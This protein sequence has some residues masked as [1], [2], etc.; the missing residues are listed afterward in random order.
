MNYTNPDGQS[1]AKIPTIKLRNKVQRLSCEGVHY[2]IIMEK[3]GIAIINKNMKGIYLIENITT[4]KKY[5]GSSSKINTMNEKIIIDSEITKYIVFDTSKNIDDIT[6]YWNTLF[7]SFLGGN[8]K[9][10]DCFGNYKGNTTAENL[11]L[12]LNVKYQSIN[13]A[14]S[15]KR[16]IKSLNISYEDIV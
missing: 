2:L 6:Q 14:I 10:I 5:F 3:V 15:K 12:K 9:V 16:R 4:N 7:K 1:A 11:S 13:N 8:I